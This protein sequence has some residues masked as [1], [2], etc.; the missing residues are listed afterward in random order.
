VD[1]RPTWPKPAQWNMRWDLFGRL[2][3]H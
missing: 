2:W 1:R 3:I